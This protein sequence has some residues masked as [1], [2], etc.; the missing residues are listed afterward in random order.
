M[1]PRARVEPGGFVATF[2]LVRM[3]VRAPGLWLWE[4]RDADDAPVLI[5]LAGL[6]AAASEAERIE[7]VCYEH[8]LG[9]ASRTLAADPE[10]GLRAHGFAGEL[11][12]RRIAFW[13][14]DG[15]GRFGG[16]PK[17]EL[18]LAR[19]ALT[20]ARQLERAHHQ[21]R[22]CPQLTEH[23]LMLGR[24]P[25]VAGV[26]LVLASDWL[27]DRTLPSRLAPEEV[28]SKRATPR[29]DLWR[30]GQA[31]RTLSEDL[32]LAAAFERLLVSLTA[33]D[34]LRRPARASEVAVAL[35]ALLAGQSA[36][37]DHGATASVAALDPERLAALL[38]RASGDSTTVDTAAPL[39]VREDDRTAVGVVTLIPPIEAAPTALVRP[40]PVVVAVP[41]EENVEL[42]REFFRREPPPANLPVKTPYWLTAAAGLLTGALAWI[43]LH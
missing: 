14:F 12:G 13:V 42:E 22:T 30:L 28:V 6:R 33:T 25:R 24:A 26:P 41:A 3:L 35:E 18:D 20:L 36:A 39:F 27:C 5:Q 37:A 4:G 40:E 43:V 9:A 23:A 8:V 7:R 34:P 2:P 29:G 15:S 38:A 10:V 31:L 11:G 32:E 16:G 21:R 19:L 17:T 1:A